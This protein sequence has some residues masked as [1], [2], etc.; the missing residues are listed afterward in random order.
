MKMINDSV[1]NGARKNLVAKKKAVTQRGVKKTA[2]LGLPLLLAACAGDND[3]ATTD[4]D[5]AESATASY[6]ISIVNVTN[7]QPLSPVA[8]LFHEAGWRGWEIGESASPSLEV[9]AES[10]DNSGFL[11]APTGEAV[12]A[13]T[14]GVIAPGQQV[15]MVFDLESNSLSQLTVASMLVNTNDA[16]T[17]F[18]GWSLED[19]ELG[20]SYSQLVSIYDAGTELNDELSATIPGPAG[21]GEGYNE[22]RETRDFVTRHPGV[23]SQG[24]GYAESALDQSHR[25][26]Q[27]A[28]LLTIERLL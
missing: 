14:D 5:G 16:F 8:V 18:T 7:E 15:Q 13:S 22:Q 27:G 3:P 12:T 6:Q 26:D 20:E 19:L 11:M 4:A 10:G 1:K 28:M 9:L 2:L 23:V 17:G 21:G 25:F 24:D